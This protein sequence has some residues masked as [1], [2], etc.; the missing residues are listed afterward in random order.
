M[1]ASTEFN[2]SAV[3]QTVATAI[4]DHTVLIWRDRRLTYAEMDS[5]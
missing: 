2:L 3:F 4:P 5:G 1:T